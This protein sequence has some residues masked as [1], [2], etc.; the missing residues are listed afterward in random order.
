M[1]WGG[2][3]W[4]ANTS[5]SFAGLEILHPSKM[6][7]LLLNDDWNDV[8]TGALFWLDISLVSLVHIA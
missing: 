5:T 6:T 8:G 1:N 4:L 7:A 2:G 3:R